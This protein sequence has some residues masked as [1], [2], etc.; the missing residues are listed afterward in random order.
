[1]SKDHKGITSLSIFDNTKDTQKSNSIYLSEARPENSLHKLHL[2][3]KTDHEC[4]YRE[5]RLK[6]KLP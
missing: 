2:K 3:K 4:N 5:K 1:M 6:G